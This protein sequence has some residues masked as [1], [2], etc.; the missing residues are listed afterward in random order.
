MG[1][2]PT[3]PRAPRRPEV[4]EHAGHQRVDDWYWLREREDPAV[5]TYLAAENEYAR[6]L[7]APFEPLRDRIDAEIKGRVRETDTSAPARHGQWEYFRRT[8]QGR[9][10]PVHCRRRVGVPGLPD[11]DA[12]PGSTPGEQVV[13]DE[14]SLA[15][16]HDYFALRGFAVD[17]DDRLLAYA[18]DV[19]GGERSTLRVRDLDGGTDL[20]DVV[21]DVYYGVAWANDRRSI[22]YVR[23]D[24]AVRPHQVWRH[25]LGTAAGDDVLVY[26][27]DDERFYVGLARTRSGRVVLIESASKLTSEVHLLDADD[28]T[29]PP[30]VV[31][32]RE[33]GVEYHV[34]HHIDGDGHERL[35]ALTN[36]GGALNFTLVS[37]ERS[38]TPADWAAWHEVIA[39]RADVRLEAV[40]AFASHLVLTERV[41]ARAGLR[42]VSLADGTTTPVAAMAEVATS[43]LGPCREFETTTVRTVST[44]LVDPVTDLDVD[45]ATGRQV[46]VKVQPVADHD[47]GRYESHRLWAT[48]PDGTGVPIS[49]VYPQGTARDGSSPLLLYG[50][51][52]YEYSIDPTFSVTRLS[53]LERGCAFAIA[54]VR[55]GGELGRTW[56]EQGRLEHKA[57][58]F[59]DFIACAEH[60]VDEGY[61]A[62]DRL[63]ARGGSAGGL[64]MGAVANLRPDLFRAVVAEVPFVDCLTTMLD[65]SLPL[66]VTEWEEWGNPGTD[67]RAYADLLA[68]SPYDNVHDQRYPAI[69]ATAGLNDPR[70][71]YWEPAKWVAKL[72]TL[73]RSDAPI[74]LKTELG[75]GH[76]GLSGRYERWREEALILAFVLGQMGVTR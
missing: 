7:L 16:G 14:N 56:Y 51:G 1:S 61:T 45:L 75:A 4:L 74:L 50:Y 15:V 27:E 46:V 73:N 40:D 25:E 55:G 42:L 13:L 20:P 19:T 53:I 36:A 54:H 23:T 35:F 66:T 71:Q 41:D 30:V 32:P 70:V 18:T 65:A 44:S 39:P 48:A 10:Y 67:E 5:L 31:M 11:P 47:P 59:T 68:Y 58:T 17:P 60:L 12:A 29:R 6:A 63:V 52:S 57:N 34:E 33:H 26:Q 76:H 49:I 64:L 72:R 24:D 28:P 2:L 69:L 38:A 21:T 8:L 3:P 43:W 9:E 62:P 22:L 37:A